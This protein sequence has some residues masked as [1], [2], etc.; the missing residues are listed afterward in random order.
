MNSLDNRDSFHELTKNGLF[1]YVF[2]INILKVEDN[3]LFCQT[4]ET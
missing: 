4:F 3:P 2:L 1:F